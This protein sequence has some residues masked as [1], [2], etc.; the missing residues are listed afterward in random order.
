MQAVY[1]CFMIC[2]A[3][4]PKNYYTAGGCK[5]VFVLWVQSRTM[6][7]KNIIFAG[8]LQVAHFNNVGPYFFGT[9]TH[10]TR[11]NTK[12]LNHHLHKQTVDP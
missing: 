7:V 2:A 12:V 3:N 10:R 9:L 1:I 11:T 8:G 4:L 5:C 6:A